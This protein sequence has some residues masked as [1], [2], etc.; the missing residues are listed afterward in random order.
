M[1]IFASACLYDIA[2]LVGTYSS[3]KK[4]KKKPKENLK[5]QNKSVSIKYLHNRPS[6]IFMKR[7]VYLWNLFPFLKVETIKKCILIT[8]KIQL[9]PRQ[10][11]VAQV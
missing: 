2:V 5:A 4:K 8:L 1:E 6:K 11:C 7:H 9:Q 10:K 3:C